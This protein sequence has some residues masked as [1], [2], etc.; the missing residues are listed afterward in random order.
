[1][2]SFIVLGTNRAKVFNNLLRRFGMLLENDSTMYYLYYV[3]YNLFNLKFTV[4]TNAQ[5]N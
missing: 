1:M 3:Y 2:N 4:T 5:I